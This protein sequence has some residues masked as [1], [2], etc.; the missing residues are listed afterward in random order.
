MAMK[1]GGRKM[2]ERIFGFIIWMLQGGQRISQIV[3]GRNG[4]DVKGYLKKK[5]HLSLGVPSFNAIKF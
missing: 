2:A 1:K 5:A 4:E 3:I